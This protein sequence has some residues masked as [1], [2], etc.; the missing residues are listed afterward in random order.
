MNEDDVSL[1]ILGNLVDYVFIVS[2]GGLL[3]GSAMILSRQLKSGSAGKKLGYIVSVLGVIAAC[4]D[5]LENVF[6]LS[7]V[8][9]PLNFPT[10]LGVPHSLFAY[11]KSSLMYISVRWVM[12]TLGYLA[13]R[14][15]WRTNTVARAT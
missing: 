8:L 1:F 15:I 7:M 4:S 10:W 12:L 14:R 2:Y 6:L 11:L 13:L 5:G 9:N 3:F